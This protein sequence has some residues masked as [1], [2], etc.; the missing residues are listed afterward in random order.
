[1]TDPHA[2][3]L[4]DHDPKVTAVL[5][6]FS[7]LMDEVVAFGTHVLRWS[8]LVTNRG[9]DENLPRLGLF[10]RL[11]DLLDGVSAQVER[12]SAESAR[13]NVR[14][15]YECALAIQYLLEADHTNRGIAY[16]VAGMHADE[17]A[18]KAL[19]PTTQQGKQTA[20]VVAA[21]RLMGGLNLP[22]IKD[23]PARLAGIQK[24]LGQ[25]SYAAVEQEYQAVKKA[26]KGR[27]PAWYALF[28]GP[29]NIYALAGHLSLGGVYAFLYRPLS[30][31]THSADAIKRAVSVTGPGKAEVHQVRL[32]SEAQLMTKIAIGLVVDTMSLYVAF[33]NP[34]KVA[35]FKKWYARQIAGNLK[36]LAKREIIDF[37]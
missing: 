6:K 36:T 33:Y 22:A 4:P 29:K 26:N 10:R 11:L 14:V 15:L 5:G 23:L 3:L 16:L 20:K 13:A 1:M 31:T 2:Q 30:G 32:A 27:D 28:G 21:D 18:Y 17:K 7:A 8:T 34:E 24:V 35:N 37:K 9:Q 19:D 12:G 25:G